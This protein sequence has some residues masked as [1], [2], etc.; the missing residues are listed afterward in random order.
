MLTFRSRAVWGSAA[1]VL[2]ALVLASAARAVPLTAG[3]V[4]VE[5]DGNGTEALSASSASVWLN[6]FT[7]TGGL[8]ATLSFPTSASGSNKPLVDGGSTTSD[9]EL[10]LSGNA[11]C[12]VTVGYDT[13]TGTEKVAETKAST[14]PRTVAVVNGKGEVDTTTAL[15]NFANENNARSATSD[16]CKTL[17]VGGNGTKTTGGVVAA[18]LGE[19]TGT[20]LNESTT[21]S[22][23]SRSSAGSSTPP[24]TRPRRAR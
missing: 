2:T 7:S 1:A 11:E 4:V 6:E 10:T 16:E 13:G 15:T 12:L 19:S 24:P 23:R 21:T 18:E 20:Q 8:A 14:V 3:D 5:R 17:W 22:A 9:G